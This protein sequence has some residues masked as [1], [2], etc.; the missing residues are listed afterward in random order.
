MPEAGMDAIAL[1][2]QQGIRVHFPM[3][4][5]C[6][7]QPAYSSGHPT[8]AFDVAK[9]QLDLF[10]ENW[11]IVV[12]SGSCGGMMKHHWPTLFKIQNTNP[13]RLIVPT[14]SLSLLIS[15]LPS[16][17]SLK[18]KASQSKSPF[19]LPVPPAEK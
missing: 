4:Q 2:E 19:T 16:A 10:P 1:I 17:T 6:C 13:K 18:T 8:E 3:A 14:V 7:G 11:P 15:C 12:P 5:S 9:A